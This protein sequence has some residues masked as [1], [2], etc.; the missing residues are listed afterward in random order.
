M[1]YLYMQTM[2]KTAPH[3]LHYPHAAAASAEQMLFNIKVKTNLRCFEAL[4][5][6]EVGG[7]LIDHVHVSLLRCHHRYGKPLQLASRQV[8]HFTVQHL[9]K[10]DARCQPWNPMAA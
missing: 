3:E 6:V 10:N 2:T 5:D 8:L 1:L 4:P 9:G 7:G